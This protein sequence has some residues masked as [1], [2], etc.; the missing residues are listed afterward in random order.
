M[1]STES[2]A[3]AGAQDGHI[4]PVDLLSNPNAQA[5]ATAF[6]AHAL[7]VESV[8][9]SLDGS[10]LLSTSSDGESVAVMPHVP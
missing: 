8:A 5:H 4:Y 9:L 1:D 2:R 6:R 7:P 10:V 3:Y